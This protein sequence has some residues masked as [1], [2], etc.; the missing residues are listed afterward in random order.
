MI[1]R[2]ENVVLAPDADD[3]IIASGDVVKSDDGGSTWQPVTSISLTLDFDDD[4]KVLARQIG[5]AAKSAATDDFLSGSPILA[6]TAKLLEGKQI[7]LG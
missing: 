4:P 6:D 5:D 2:L 1:Y 3:K 7:T